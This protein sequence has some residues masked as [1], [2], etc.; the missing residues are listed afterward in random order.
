L[1]VVQ[2]NQIINKFLRF[3]LKCTDAKALS[4]LKKE[5]KNINF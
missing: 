2:Q 3:N 4:N 5:N 1:N